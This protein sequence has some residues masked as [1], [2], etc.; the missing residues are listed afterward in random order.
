[1]VHINH[2]RDNSMLTLIKGDPQQQILQSTLSLTNPTLQTVK[3]I[4][5][6]WAR[7]GLISYLYD[8]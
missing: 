8:R 3:T 5:I 6:K 4:A 1:M 2:E 7:F